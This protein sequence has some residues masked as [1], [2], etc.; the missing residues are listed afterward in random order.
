MPDRNSPEAIRRELLVR[1]LWYG[2]GIALALGILRVAAEF[3][4]GTWAGFVIQ[5]ANFLPF[6]L[7]APLFTTTVALAI[8]HLQLNAKFDEHVTKSSQNLGKIE[9]SVASAQ[10]ANHRIAS[11]E[12]HLRDEEDYTILVRIAAEWRQINSM[13]LTRPELRDLVQWKQKAI[14]SELW[15]NWDKLGKGVMLVSDSDQEFELNALV[16]RLLSPKL[17]RAVSW[18]D[19]S[20]WP[21]GFGKAFLSQQSEYLKGD[22]GREVRRVFFTNPDVDYTEIFKQQ[23][24]AGIAVRHISLDEITRAKRKP[25]DVVIYDARCLKVSQVVGRGQGDGAELKEAELY[26][27]AEKVEPAIRSFDD[28][29]EAASNVELPHD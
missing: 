29:W 18:N 24:N 25:Q 20:Y 19:E 13:L 4:T 11:L 21:S 7:I 28:I 2:A 26:F 6:M 12:P 15:K 27:M 22:A 16:L 9:E 23:I 17:V 1:P 3:V 14:L 8:R 10:L 5:I